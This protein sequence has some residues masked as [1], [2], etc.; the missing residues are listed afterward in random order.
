LRIQSTVSELNGWGNG[1]ER[2]EAIDSRS[3]NEVQRDYRLSVAGAPDTY[4]LPYYSFGA[5]RSR[6]TEKYTVDVFGP[7]LGPH[8]GAIHT[9]A[10]VRNSVVHSFA[11]LMDGTRVANTYESFLDTPNRT[12]LTLRVKVRNNNTGMV[13]EVT[14]RWQPILITAGVTVTG[15]VRVNNASNSPLPN[16]ASGAAPTSNRWVNWLTSSTLDEDFIMLSWVGRNNSTSA[17]EDGFIDDFM[18]NGNP[19]TAV[20]NMP[21]TDQHGNQAKPGTWNIVETQSALINESPAAVLPLVADGASYTVLAIDATR[22]PWVT[23]SR[24]QG[25]Y[26]PA[27]V[28]ISGADVV[29]TTFAEI[30]AAQTVSLTTHMDWVFYMDPS[31]H[32]DRGAGSGYPYSTVPEN[33]LR[34]GD[35]FRILGPAAIVPPFAGT[36]EQAT[37]EIYGERSR[38]MTELIPGMPT[39]S[40]VYDDQTGDCRTTNDCDAAYQGA[41]WFPIVGGVLTFEGLQVDFGTPNDPDNNGAEDVQIVMPQPEAVVKAADGTSV[42]LYAG[43]IIYPKGNYALNAN[44][45]PNGNYQLISDD[46]IVAHVDVSPVRRNINRQVRTHHPQNLDGGIF[47]YTPVVASDPDC[48][49]EP[50]GF[51]VPG[52]LFDFDARAI[53]RANTVTLDAWT[54]GSG[55]Y[56]PTSTFAQDSPLCSI[57][58]V[59]NNADEFGCYSTS[60][61]DRF[62]ANPFF[63]RSGIYY[64]NDPDGEAYHAHRAFGNA[65]ASSPERNTK[66]PPTGVA[67]RGH[68]ISPLRI[69]ESYNRGIIADSHGLTLLT[70]HHSGATVFSAPRFTPHS[71]VIEINP[72]SV[73]VAASIALPNRNTDVNFINPSAYHW[74]KNGTYFIPLGVEDINIASYD[75]YIFNQVGVNITTT[76]DEFDSLRLLHNISIPLNSRIELNSYGDDT[77]PSQANNFFTFPAGS[78]AIVVNNDMGSWLAAN[79]YLG[80]YQQG[81]VID[82]LTLGAVADTAQIPVINDSYYQV[83]LAGKH[84]V[85]YQRSEA[86]EHD[87]PNSNVPLY[88]NIWLRLP[89]GGRLFDPN[90]GDT[91]ELAANSIVNPILGTY[92]SGA[93]DPLGAIGGNL[94][95]EYETQAYLNSPLHLVRPALT[96]PVGAR[97]VV[98]VNGGIIRN[99][100]AAAI[101]S[102]T[103]LESI[104]CPTGV[105]DG[106]SGQNGTPV[107]LNQKREGIFE[108]NYDDTGAGGSGREFGFSHPCAWLDDP[109]NMDGD[110]Y[111]VY[112]NRRRYGSE[113]KIQTTSNDRTYLLGGKLELR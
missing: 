47:N 9:N 102:L 103:P 72:T 64:T 3:L 111:Y 12:H 67:F 37:R 35:D 58:A 15:V 2:P 89:A 105:L 5:F 98:G 112:R 94:V 32:P 87:E 81:A 91:I 51:T 73:P 59:A 109:E 34:F 23:I 57:P 38:L 74:K 43:A 69:D 29:V 36:N 93:E 86:S 56:P 11:E 90:S 25:Y 106:Y 107:L 113:F 50:L 76:G 30:G 78:E 97:I 33:I 99:V 46:V 100:K 18:C 39:L 75:S 1:K 95:N 16:S 54:S 44:P 8:T 31:Y 61:P 71:R 20:F 84:V 21:H 48:I 24:P 110:R 19:A 4:E 17:P 88:T 41:D 49:V 10:I 14:A 66:A 6:R 45:I 65:R 60:S 101:F 70:E 40:H 55:L 79:P 104:Q 13:E 63:Y 28:T 96:L 82:L 68:S 77:H 83:N 26:V 85:H 92:L 80:L 27:T 53:V 62:T 22:P 42:T 52:P 108:N 7:D